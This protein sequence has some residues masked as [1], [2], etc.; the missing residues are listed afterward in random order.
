MSFALDTLLREFPNTL[1]TIEWHSPGFT[2][3]WSDFDLP[4]VYDARSNLY[5][6]GG[7]PHTQWN[8]IESFVGGA[9][10]CV[11]EYMY[12]DRRNTYE[13]YAVQESPYT[14]ELQGDL[15]D[16][17]GSSPVFNFDVII[18]LED[19]FSSSGTV[20]ELFVAEDSIMAYWSACG[21]EHNARNVGR[22]WLTMDEDD[23]VPITI[24]GSGQS[25]V[26]SGSFDVSNSWNHDRVKL[27]ALAQNLVTNEVFQA[28]TELILNIPTD[29]DEDGITNLEDNCPDDA[30]PGQEDLDGDD[31]GDICDPCNGLVYVL[32][33]VNGDAN[34]GYDP[35][36]D[37]ID[38]LALSDYLEDPVYN[39]CQMLDLLEDGEINQWDLIVLADL[40]MNGGS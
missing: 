27:I 1:M 3:G 6:V 31:I 26:H 38:L 11:W 14:I 24:S 22:A 40:V 2:P 13:D 25:Q 18:S 19:D 28:Q 20:L 23:Q 34:E 32:G 37:V 5:D 35:I 36:V 9:S 21:E 12:N 8:G 30:N 15:V 4:D 16:S 39:E 10:N 29:R 7:I 33:N 17:D